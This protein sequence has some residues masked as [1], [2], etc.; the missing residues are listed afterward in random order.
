MHELGGR[1]GGDGAVR[2]LVEHECGVPRAVEREIAAEHHDAV[3]LLTRRCP[4]AQYPDFRVEDP[5]L[6]GSGN[7]GHA[8]LDERHDAPVG[9]HVDAT[10]LAEHRGVISVA[11]H[12]V[13]QPHRVLRFAGLELVRD[14]ERERHGQQRGEVEGVRR[15]DGDLDT[16]PGRWAQRLRQDDA[17]L[18]SKRHD[19]LRAAYRSC[20]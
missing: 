18:R 19:G 2:R 9:G 11:A 1:G 5:A 13:E 12:R 8:V 16:E 7:L 15:A 17:H 14:G 10:G 20:R 4:E 6:G 3:A